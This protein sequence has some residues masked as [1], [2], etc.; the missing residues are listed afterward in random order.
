MAENYTFF[1][2][3]KKRAFLFNYGR[4]EF[5]LQVAGIFFLKQ[6]SWKGFR[7]ELGIGWKGN[8]INM[9]VVSTTI[10]FG[11]KHDQNESDM[12]WLIWPV[13]RWFHSTVLWPQL[14]LWSWAW[15]DKHHFGLNFQARHARCSLLES[16]YNPR[17]FASSLNC[18]LPWSMGYQHYTVS[19]TP[20]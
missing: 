3:L 7:Q 11:G 4:S 20:I 9:K 6:R 12:L 1:F 10:I 2:F 18:L 16:K 17:G 14:S 19:C 15:E 8:T 13:S 5:L